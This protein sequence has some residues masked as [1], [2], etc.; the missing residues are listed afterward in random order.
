M[1]EI[2]DERNHMGAAR[3]AYV[4]GLVNQEILL[5]N[6]YLAAENRISILPVAL[7]TT[8]LSRHSPFLSPN[9]STP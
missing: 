5:Q 4:T 9:D 7:R 1:M 6:E 8:Y 2:E 3:L